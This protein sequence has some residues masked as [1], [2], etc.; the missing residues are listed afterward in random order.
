LPGSAIHTVG[1]RDRWGGRSFAREWP[2]PRPRLA[3]RDQPRDRDLVAAAPT[4]TV[5][6]ARRVK[7]FAPASQA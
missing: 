4:V 1:E 5:R 2:A 7:V 6:V 3:P